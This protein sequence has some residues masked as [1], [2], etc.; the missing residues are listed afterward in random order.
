MTALNFPATPSDG[1]TF[2]N[3][4]YDG[5]KEVWRIQP[6]IPGISSRFKVSATA[7]TNPAD[8]EVWLNSTDGNTYIYY[9]DGDTAQWIEI[10]GTTGNPPD[11]DSLNDVT[12]TSP[13]TDQLLRWNGT[14][15]V[16]GTANTN[17]IADGAVTAPKLANT[18]GAVMVFDDAT[19]RTTAIPTPVEGMT[20]YL[21]D[22]DAVEFFD[23]SVFRRVGGLI[24]VKSAIRDTPEVF[25][26]VGSGSNFAVGGLSITHE[27]ADPANRLIITAVLNGANSTTGGEVGVAVHDGTGLISQPASPGSRTAV[28]GGGLPAGAGNV[29]QINLYSATFVHTPG[30]GSKTYTLRIVNVRGD[31]RN[32]FVNRSSGDADNAGSSRTISTLTIQEVAV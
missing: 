21:K 29:V 27:V 16:N 9:S 7:P 31:T 1:D 23:G 22:L 20:T 5:V 12:I 18:A 10:G 6:N 13:T 26:S 14:A 24:A 25:S 2:D 8:G 30:A 17:S 28:L 19:A 3:Y 15:W 11:L 32:L 4:I